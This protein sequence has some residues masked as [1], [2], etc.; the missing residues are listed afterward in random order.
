MCARRPTPDKGK[1]SGMNERLAHIAFAV[2]LLTIGALGQGIGTATGTVQ[3]MVFTADANGGRSVVPAAKISLDGPA[4]LQLQ[5]DNEGKF[6]FKAVPPGSYRIS[7]E[8]TGLAATQNV[9]DFLSGADAAE[10]LT[11]RVN[12]RLK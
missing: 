6:A 10:Q 5:T 9:L 11:N 4:H 1:T 7:A 12:Q 8:A 2:G 3:G